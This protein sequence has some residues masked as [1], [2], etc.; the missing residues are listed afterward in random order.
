MA[1]TTYSLV[2]SPQTQILMSPF[3]ATV[4]IFHGSFRTFSIPYDPAASQ[5]NFNPA[6]SQ[7]NFNPARILTS[8]AIGGEVDKTTLV[9]QVFWSPEAAVERL[10]SSVDQYAFRH[11]ERGIFSQN[12]QVRE[13]GSG[14]GV[15][16]LRD[17]S[18][19]MEMYITLG[20]L[21]WNADRS[22]N[23]EGEFLDE[24]VGT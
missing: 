15:V 11:F 12:V 4:W 17:G 20:C 2:Q 19:A 24:E 13:D 16:F 7:V 1:L 5:A 6:A 10:L 21:G 23:V 22:V 14:W 18:R 9:R 3:N 8:S